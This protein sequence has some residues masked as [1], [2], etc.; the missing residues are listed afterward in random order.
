MIVNNIIG[1]N[2]KMLRENMGVNQL[3]FAHFLNV[4]QSLV[5]KIEKGERNVSINM[6][7]K[8]SCLFGVAV[9]DVE[10]G[11]LETSNLPF[12]FRANDLSV[13]DME[14]ISAINRIA[15]NSEQMAKMLEV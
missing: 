4:D 10:N 3:A 2:I 15:L 14:A 9:D 8:I 5:S 7:E 13:E 12:A 11:A 6:L 1:K